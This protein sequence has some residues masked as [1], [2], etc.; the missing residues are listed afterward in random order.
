MSGTLHPAPIT[1]IRP[2]RGLFDFSLGEVWQY[3]ELLYFLVWRDLKVRYSQ[4]ALGAA[5][6]IIQPL[7]AVA[8]FTVIFGVFAKLPSDGIPYPVFAFSAMLPWTLFSESTR[9]C[10][11]GLV[12]D[13]DLVKKVYFPR[14]VI[15]LAN[16][17]TPVIDFFLSLF[18][19]FLLMAIY[20]VWP[21][22]NIVF[23]PFLVA[24][25][26]GLA[27]G[28]GLWLGPLNVRFRD[29]TH[30]LPF[31][32]QIWM[33]AT[34][35]VYPLSMVPERFKFLYSLNPTVGLIEGYRWCLLGTN[36]LD[37]RALAISV[38]ATLALLFSGLVYFKQQERQFADII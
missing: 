10:A 21:S 29:I 23:L 12:G 35:I 28:I 15:P 30:T 25:T 37:L 31:L 17:V 19:L 27:V 6:A 4:A 11:L 36:S 18:A 34:P 16:A 24:L 7:V 13:G 22:M 1:L 33:Y 3:R 20:G 14:L 5:W 26:W 38:V 32:L 9:R 2:R 8:I